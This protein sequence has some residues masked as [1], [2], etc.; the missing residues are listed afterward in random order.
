MKNKTLNKTEIVGLFGIL[1][2]GLVAPALPIATA[3]ETTIC[4]SLIEEGTFEK[5]EVPIN[6]TCNMYS[7]SGSITI[8]GDVVVEEGGTLHMVAYGESFTVGGNIKA[9]DADKVTLNGIA[10]NGNI[11]IK[12]AESGVTISSV[13]VQGNLQLDKN[14]HHYSVVNSIIDGN[15]QIDR[16]TSIYE[17]GL[18]NN[19]AGN[20]VGGNL[21]CKDNQPAPVNAVFGPNTVNGNKKGQCANF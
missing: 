1:L 10:V 4:D 16:N 6:A 20:T 13:T 3:A 2:L 19:F 11:Q 14:E 8:D 9:D 7:S 17:S 18:Y 21:D 12:N 5:I 15:L